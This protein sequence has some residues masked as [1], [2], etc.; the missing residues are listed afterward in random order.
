MIA[1]PDHET[2]ARAAAIARTGL[3]GIELRS[4]VDEPLIDEAWRPLVERCLH[5]RIVGLLAAAVESGELPVTAIQREE[6]LTHHRERLSTCLLIEQQ[7]LATERLLEQVGVEIRVLKGPAVAHLDYP[8][9]AMR[10]FNDVDIL[11]PPQHVDRAVSELIGAGY[12]RRFAEVRPGFDARFSKGVELF[13]GTDPEIDLHRTFVMGPYGLWI[14]TDD[15]WRSVERF[16]LGGRQLSAFDL[17][18]RF[19]HACY[20]VALGGLDPRLAQLRDIPQLLT[21]EGGGPDIDRCVAIARRWQGEAVV[22]RA[23]VLAW[24][25]LGLDETD[26]SRWAREYSPDARER[27]AMRSYLDPRMGYA[28]R[29]LTA[30]AAVP[31][32]RSKAAFTWGLAFPSEDY[33]A[34]RHAGRRQRWGRALGDVRRLVS[35]G[36]SGPDSKR[37]V[38]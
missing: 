26:L 25:G 19:V 8:D 31:G 11:V 24:D 16:E 22:A 23:V 37:H 38:P 4:V 30:V 36:R 32:W 7:L 34:G 14:D 9:P 10:S 29:C 20:H 1:A 6:V 21:R 27:R 33:G 17:D 18:V 5:H 13:N 2:R 28:A 12:T 15:L 35:P 3:A